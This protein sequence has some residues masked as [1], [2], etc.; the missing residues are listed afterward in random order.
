MYEPE[1]ET[2]SFAPFTCFRCGQFGHVWTACRRPAAKTKQELAQRV[3]ELV[4]R[5]DAG[6]VK[7]FS[8][9]VK[10]AIVIAETK[11]FEKARKAA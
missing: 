1:D 11:A 6:S 10:T 2:E 7:G 3:A 9:G 8:H 5:W 4:I